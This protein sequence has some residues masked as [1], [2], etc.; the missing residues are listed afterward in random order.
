MSY[1]LKYLLSLFGFVVILSPTIPQV[2]H[3]NKGQSQ[4]IGSVSNG[5]LINGFKVPR[6]GKNFRYF[7]VIDYYLLGRCYVHSDIYRIV[8]ESY[9]EL[10]ELYP[11][12]IFRVMECSK[13]NG[14]KVFPHRTHQNGTSIDFMTPL[15]KDKR[16]Q[17]WFD[18]AGIWRYLMNFDQTGTCKLNKKVKIDFEKLARHILVLESVA[19][20]NGYR[21]RKVILETN[22]KDELFKTKS[23]KELKS[24]GIYFVKNLPPKINVLHDDHFHVDFVKL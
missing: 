20:Q 8:I 14:G 7:S 19:R 16:E 4:S 10:E 23:G 21:L 9:C 15:M 5:K 2:F 18:K 13:K 17:I 11:D 24:S 22:L 1:K 3:K 12:Y 6:K